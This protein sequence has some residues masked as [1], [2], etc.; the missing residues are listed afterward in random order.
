[1]I[2]LIANYHHIAKN[3]LKKEYPV[4]NS[5]LGGGGG[6]GGGGLKKK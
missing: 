6:G 5:L 4:T 3:I 2:F 1:V